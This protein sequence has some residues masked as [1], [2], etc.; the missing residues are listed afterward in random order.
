MTRYFF[1][2]F[3]LMI[4]YLSYSQVEVLGG[5]A[6]DTVVIGD[7]VDMTLSVE[8][9]KG[10]NV[11]AV[12]GYFLDSI[13]SGLQTA[14]ANVD[15]TQP[16]IPAIADFEILSFGGWED[17]NDD[18]LFAGGELT[19]DT[20]S[21]GSQMILEQ[22]FSIRMWDPGP[23]VMLYPAVLYTKDGQQDQA[24][25]ESQMQLF[26]AP[27][28]GLPPVQD[29]L[30]VAPIKTIKEEATNLSDFLI[31]FI[32]IGL[33][34]VLGLIYWWYTK[35]YKNR[36]LRQ[37]EVVVPDVFVPS[38]QIALKKL[39]DLKGKQLWQQGDIKTYQSELTYIIR[40]YLEGR[41]DISALESTTDEIVKNLSEELQSND[42]V[43]SLKRIL[44]V[45]DLVK[46]AKAKPD[47]N[48]HESFMTEA[49]S[50]VERTADDT[51][52]VVLKD[53]DLLDEIDN[54]SEL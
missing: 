51:K 20:T 50:F 18:G 5:F 54:Q 19:W 21:I 6:T 36:E 11:L 12:T 52:Q 1:V 22:T 28:G 15:T 10:A 43:I 37:A 26:V 35:Y 23:N 38:H 9:E 53:D 30:K 13:Y 14:K 3:F 49:E 8:V 33:A 39:S 34:L 40:E 44:Q 4:G 29:S 25:N 7:A 41:Y 31:Y 17:A 16:V 47:E 24:I 48:L 27:P 46:F 42:D 45:A 2:F 32:I